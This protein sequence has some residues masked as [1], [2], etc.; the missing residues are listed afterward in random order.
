MININWQQLPI[1]IRREFWEHR[2]AFQYT[3]LI[4]AGLGILITI[5]VSIF[6]AEVDGNNL[7]TCLLYTS[8]SPRDLST[9]RMPSSA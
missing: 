4:L 5:M 9:S 8:P 7:F 6:A 2:W 1:L 3:P